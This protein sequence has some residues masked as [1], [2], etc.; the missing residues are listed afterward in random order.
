MTD[1]ILGTSIVFQLR[2]DYYIG[3]VFYA[4]KLGYFNFTT[5]KMSCTKCTDF[6]WGKENKVVIGEKNSYPHAIIKQRKEDFV[7]EYNE[8]KRSQTI[9]IAKIQQGYGKSYLNVLIEKSTS[10]N[11]VFDEF[12]GG[13]FGFIAKQKYEFYNSVQDLG[14]STVK[15]NGRFV[16]TFLKSKGGQ[17][18]GCHSMSLEDILYPKNV[19]F[20]QKSL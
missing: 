3:K 18:D 12:H 9:R 10:V 7:I 16:K 4:T 5:T 17:N 20:F 1:Q 2:D 6:E 14:V 15:L 19:K 8:E 13:L 11:G